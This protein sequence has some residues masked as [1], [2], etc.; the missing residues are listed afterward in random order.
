MYLPFC[1]IEAIGAQATKEWSLENALK[2]MKSE[3][4][5]MELILIAYRDT[6]RCVT[7]E[8]FFHFIRNTE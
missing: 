1:S 7:A 3:W 8:C 6:V 4:I 5:D 2:K